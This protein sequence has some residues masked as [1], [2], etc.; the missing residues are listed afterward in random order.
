MMV[1]AVAVVVMGVMR[2]A[3]MEVKVV[4]FLKVEL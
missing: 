3:G 2:L 1:E 4:V